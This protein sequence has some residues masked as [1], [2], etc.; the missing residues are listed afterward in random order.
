[1]SNEAAAQTDTGDWA[2]VEVFGH[3]RL[4][5][6]ISEEERFGA[7]MLR[8]DVPTVEFTEPSTEHPQGERYVAGWTTQWYGGASLFSV[9]PSDEVSALRAR[10]PYPPHRLTSLPTP[11]TPEPSLDDDEERPW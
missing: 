7:K 9:T 5:G 1:M 8:I 3:R 4:A 11:S 2:I 10:A 6:R